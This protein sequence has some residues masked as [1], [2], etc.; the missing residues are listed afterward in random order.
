[1]CEARPERGF[2][3]QLKGFGKGLDDLVMTSNGVIFATMIT[4]FVVLKHG[5]VTTETTRG[6]AWVGKSLA[7]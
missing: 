1:M 4:H 3:E 2:V 7:V 5:F 6:S